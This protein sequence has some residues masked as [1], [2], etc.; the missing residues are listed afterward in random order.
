MATCGTSGTFNALACTANSCTPT[1]VSNSDVATAGSIT[2]VT[3]EVSR[4]IL[5]ECLCP[6]LFLAFDVL[7]LSDRLLF[8]FSCILSGDTCVFF[9]CVHM[10]DT[11]CDLQCGL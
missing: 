4:F 8:F 5:S 1:Q 10:S 3:G 6:D 9:Q 2:G 11:Q 7:W